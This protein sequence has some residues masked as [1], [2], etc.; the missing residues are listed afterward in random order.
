MTLSRKMGL[1]YLTRKLQATGKTQRFVR[2]W[3][4]AFLKAQIF[5]EIPKIVFSSLNLTYQKPGKLKCVLDLRKKKWQFKSYI[6]H[7]KPWQQINFSFCCL[8]QKNW[9]FLLFSWAL[10]T[11]ESTRPNCK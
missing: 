1:R 9:V 11:R 5:L 3:Y 8:R 10:Y 7:K 4:A 2:L 6:L